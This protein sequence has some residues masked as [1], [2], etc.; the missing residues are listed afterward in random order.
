M[1]IAMASCGGVPLGMLCGIYLAEYAKDNWFSHFIRLVVD[2]VAGVPS[3][4]V[5]LLGYELAVVR[6]APFA[7]TE[8]GSLGFLQSAANFF[9]GVHN[10]I[11]PGGFSAWA[12][13]IALAFIMC[14]IIARTTKEMLKLVPDASPR[15]R[16]GWGRPSFRRC[17]AW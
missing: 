7:A 2:V 4:I 11:F 15:R 10:A 12:G 14:P 13:A 1:L 5:G 3:I 9:I 6:T 16:W 8:G 17:F